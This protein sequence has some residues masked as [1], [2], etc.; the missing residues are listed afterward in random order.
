M[1]HTLRELLSGNGKLRLIGAHDGLSAVLAERLGFEGIWAS[2]LAISTANALPDEG[3]LTMTEFHQAAVRIRQASALP[4]VADV[5]SGFGD[6]PVVRRMTRLYEQAGID[7]IC[8]EDKRYPKR[9]SFQDDNHLES[10]ETAVARIKAAKAAQ[11][12]E[13]FMVIARQESLIAQ[14]GMDD[15]LARAHRYRDAGADALL[16]HSRS[17][18]AD[19]VREYCARLHETDIA[20][21]VFAIPTTY[22]RSTVQE[23][24]SCGVSATI[25]ANQ[26]VRASVRAMTEVLESLAALGSTSAVEDGIAP[27]AELFSL[28]GMDA[29]AHSAE[30]GG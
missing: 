16:I 28:V 8:I 12:G 23:L 17:P 30:Q 5:D 29:P 7:A 20:L 11:R 1:T 24:W 25:Y 19:E 27:L 18:V 22:Y 9:N 3:L 26:L 13:D 4:I 15:A 21:P 14:V 10:V 6:L 2:G